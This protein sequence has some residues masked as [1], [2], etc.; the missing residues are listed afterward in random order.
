MYM[1]TEQY[2]CRHKHYALN[3]LHLYL[4]PYYTILI[5]NTAKPFSVHLLVEVSISGIAY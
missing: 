1:C 4:W 3:S 2:I 5:I